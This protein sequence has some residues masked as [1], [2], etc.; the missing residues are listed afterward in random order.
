[1][2]QTTFNG[3]ITI[4][5]AK[6]VLNDIPH[7][8]GLIEYGV[9]PLTERLTKFYHATPWSTWEQTVSKEGLTPQPLSRWI[10]G[11][12]RSGVYL[13][14][15]K[16]SILYFV[17]ASWYGLLSIY[18]TEEEIRN[19]VRPL[20]PFALLE[21]YILKDIYVFPDTYYV[22]EDGTYG[23]YIITR[24][25]P[26][27]NIQLAGRIVPSMKRAREWMEENR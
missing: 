5:L 15:T 10:P 27:A 20:E 21:A 9:K 11:D 7:A 14:T 2:I 8:A 4:L 6:L 24:P 23:A 13:G 25:I 16:K 18:Q 3:M 12:T 19:E 17:E 1:M 22:L 26:R